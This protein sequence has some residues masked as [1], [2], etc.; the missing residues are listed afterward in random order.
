[1]KPEDVL[2]KGAAELGVELSS[3][4]VRLF[5]LYL[6]SLKFWNE[7]INL[8]GINDDGQI[9]VNHFLDS[10][11]VA[12]FIADGSKLLDIGSGG[13]FPGIP[14]KIVNP[15]LEVTL[16]ESIQKKVFFMRDII[17]KLGL[18]RIQS[19]CGRAEDADNGVPRKYFNFVVS[20]AVGRIENLIE[21]GIPY[22]RGE[23]E[24]ILMRGKRGLEEWNQLDNTYGNLR[25]LNLKRLLLPFG[26]HQRV[27]LVI[28]KVL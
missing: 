17:R 8:T 1:M 12:P 15:S 18:D 27:L 10:I 4:Q 7:K 6:D 2:T 24:I 11:S 3:G 25:L 26:N 16:L 14:L 9:V 19:V 28:G 20:R 21:L 5:L 22:L 23:G 13:G